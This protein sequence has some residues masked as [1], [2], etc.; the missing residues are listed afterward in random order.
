MAPV[1]PGGTIWV[2]ATRIAPLDVNGF[3][4]AG[5][6]CFVTNTTMKV[7][8]TEVTESGD[9]IAIK[10]AAGDLSVW[11]RHGDIP[12]YGTVNFEMAQ[13]D[14]QLEAL[15]AGG[16]SVTASG[17]ALGLPTG[18]TATPQITLG[19]LAAGTYTYRATQYNA[20]GETAAEAEVAATVASGS[21]GTVVLSGVTMAAGALGVRLYGRNQGTEQLIGSYINI[22]SQAT[23]A[24]SGTGAVANLS[25]TALTQPLPY[26][27]TFQISG[28]TNTVKIIFTVSQTTGVGA[29]S[30]PVTVSQSV[31][32]TIAAAAIVPVFVDT[33]A[34]IPAGAVPTVDL[35][36]GPGVGSGYQAPALGIVGNPYGVSMEF[37]S[38]HIINGYQ[39]SVY[40]Y[41]WTVLPR[42]ANLH[43]M[44]Y[45]LTN[46]NKVNQF[47]GQGFQNP[48]WS[49]G[50][51]GTYPNDTTK[52]RQRTFCGAQVLPVSSLTGVAAQS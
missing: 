34:A 20:Y 3:A 27:Y 26:G 10:N 9:D 41:I 33:G 19:T 6:S 4:A 40:P 31:T 49:S 8:L 22:G 17:A 24:A 29:T 48:N 2:V 44:P 28:D 23:S 45:D 47:E 50:P 5:V 25:V 46:A 21:T 43:S 15:L 37:W 52:W 18:L 12:K 14:D 35:T 16:I 30:L 42:V 1:T 32:T 39:D 7:T 51:F 13:A 36:A 11:A 38:K